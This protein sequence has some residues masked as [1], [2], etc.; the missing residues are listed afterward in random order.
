MAF[1]SRMTHGNFNN[2]KLVDEYFAEFFDRSQELL[3]DTIL[4]LAGDHG[5]R[6][7]YSN[8]NGIGRLEER[9]NLV[10]VRIPDSLNNKHPH[11]RMFLEANRHRLISWLDNHQMMLDVTKNDFAPLR[12]MKS[13]PIS[14]WR[15]VARA[16]RSCSDA[17]I[18]S[19]Y[20]VCD[21]Q[22]SVNKNKND[23]FQASKNFVQFVNR[24]IKNSFSLKGCK[25]QGLNQT[26]DFK[27]LIPGPG[28]SMVMDRAVGRV[29]IQ[30][31]FLE[32]EF[33]TQRNLN[34]SVKKIKWSIDKKASFRVPKVNHD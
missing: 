17:G 29:L 31:S 7:G 10:S 13:G 6:W 20:C 34:E 18:N 26:L 33:E 24:I 4:I 5:P 15:Q 14:P 9:M 12:T 22:I 3:K 27:Y 32:F 23:V 30:P 21:G 16:D 8:S 28:E 2:F 19:E 1:Q 25:N 11:L